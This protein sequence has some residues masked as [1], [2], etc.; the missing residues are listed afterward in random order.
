L[1]DVA[2]AFSVSGKLTEPVVEVAPGVKAGRVAKETLTL[3]FNVL[4]LLLPRAHSED[5]HRPCVVEG[6]P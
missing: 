5:M 6:S 4:G 2:T 3:P 1:V